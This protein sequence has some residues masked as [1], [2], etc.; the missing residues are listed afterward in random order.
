MQ[1]FTVCLIAA[2]CAFQAIDAFTFTEMRLLVE[3]PKIQINSA[4][5]TVE[6]A[7]RELKLDYD[8][9]LPA[10][11]TDYMTQINNIV[12]PILQKFRHDVDV[13]KAEG[14]DAEAC[15]TDAKGNLRDISKNGFAAL[16]KCQSTAKT[17]VD[18]GFARLDQL[19]N[20][21]KNLLSQYDHVHLKC[22]GINIFQTRNCITTEL[23]S[24]TGATS[25]FTATANSVKSELQRNNNAAFSTANTCFTNEISDVRKKCSEL[26]YAVDACCRIA[27]IYLSPIA[28][29]RIV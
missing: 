13:A 19:V 21:G 23:V 18:N 4:I 26:G 24:L 5:G 9:R 22:N 6:S 29:P 17:V 1:A 16:D 12:N 10:K 2:L 11:K 27:D 8:R 14:R 28:I 25:T 15:Y 3:R 7:K 20:E